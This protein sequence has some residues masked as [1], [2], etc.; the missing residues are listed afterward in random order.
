MIRQHPVHVIA[1]GYVHIYIYI[2][3]CVNQDEFVW[4]HR[5]LAQGSI[6]I[7]HTNYTDLYTYLLR[8]QIYTYIY[9]QNVYGFAN[10]TCEFSLKVC[11]VC[12]FAYIPQTEKIRRQIIAFTRVFWSQSQISMIHIVVQWDQ[13]YIQIRTVTIILFPSAVSGVIKHIYTLVIFMHYVYVYMYKL[14]GIYIY[15]CIQIYIQTYIQIY[16]YICVYKYI[17]K[18]ACITCSIWRS[19]S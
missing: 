15:M 5:P 4:P 8:L 17:Y 2:Y 6:Y 16:I 14:H 1:H 13:A 7:F 12:V 18:Y 9:T 19:T 3:E 10:S 11:M